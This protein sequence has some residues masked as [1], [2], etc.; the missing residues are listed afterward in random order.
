MNVKQKLV[1]LL[2]ALAIVGMMIYPPFQITVRGTEINMG[3]RYFLD[4]PKRGAFS[5]SVNVPVLLVQLIAAV[6]VGVVGWFL[7]KGEAGP[8]SAEPRIRDSENK[9]LVESASF[10]LLRLLR[11]T[12]AIFFVLQIIG[13]LPVLTWFSNPH[14]ISDDMWIQLVIK[15]V[16]FIVFGLLF[17]ALRILIHRLHNR[18]YGSPHPT[19]TSVWAL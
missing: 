10:G 8:V 6:L 17:F 19:L 12:V 13:L 2:F 7:V 16:A 1:L 18:W 9:S 15:I 4:P 3:Y 11:G 5:A 14:V